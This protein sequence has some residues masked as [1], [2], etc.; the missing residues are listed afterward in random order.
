M[1]IRHVS[2]KD[3]IPGF[4]EQVND[5]FRQLNPNIQ[6]LDINVLLESETPPTIICCQE[7]EQLL[8]LA[9]MASYK[10]LSGHK[11]WVEDVVVRESS[12]GKG[13]GKA[14]MM[15]LLKTGKQKGLS[16]ILLFLYLI[17]PP[18]H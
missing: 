17:F 10:V 14:L 12:R 2:P 16:E 6:P 5:L 13:I 18:N 7:G 8:G 4:R 15:E 3:I 1:T 11:G 9:C